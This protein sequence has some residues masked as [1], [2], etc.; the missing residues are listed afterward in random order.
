MSTSFCPLQLAMYVWPVLSCLSQQAVADTHVVQCD[1][2][3][4]VCECNASASVCHFQFNVELVYTFMRHNLSLPFREGEIFFFNDDGELV[5]SQKK[6]MCIEDDLVKYT[7][8]GYNGVPFE[9]YCVNVTTIS[10]NVCIDKGKLCT[11]PITVDSMTFKPVIAINKQFPGPTLILHEGQTIVVDVHNNLISESVSIHWHGQHQV[12]TNWMDGVGLVTQSPIQPE[13]S[14]RYIFKASPSGTFWY[15]S[16]M[17]SQRANGLFGALVVRERELSYPISFEDNPSAHTITLMDW[18]REDLTQLISRKLQTYIDILTFAVPTPADEKYEDT[19]SS[20]GTKIGNIPYWCGLINGK[21]KHPSVAY[22]QSRLTILEVIQ[23]H[24]YRF[25]LIHT[26]VHYAYRFSIDGHKVTVM[27]TDGYI[28]QPTEVDYIAI[29]SGERYDFLLKARKEVDNFWIIAE[30]FEADFGRSCPYSSLN[31]TAEGILHY[32]GSTSPTSKEYGKILRRPRKCT[33]GNR[34]KMLNCPF[35]EFHSS[36]NIECI[37]VDTLKLVSPTQASQMPDESPDLT[38][39]LNIAGFVSRNTTFSSINDKNFVFPPNPPAL[40][41]DSIPS[42][43]FCD[44]NINCT[45]DKI[46]RCTTVIDFPYNKTIRVVMSS[47]GIERNAVHPM[48]LHGHS[49]HVVA[50]GHGTYSQDDGILLASSRDLSCSGDMDDSSTMDQNRC[51]NPRWRNSSTHFSLDQFTVRKDTIIVPSGGYVV[52]QF[53]SDNPGF[54][55]LHCHMDVHLHEGLAL[56][57]REAIDEMTR[58]PEGMSMCGSFTWDVKSFDAI[59]TGGQR[60]NTSYLLLFY[61]YILILLCLC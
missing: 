28:V 20:D 60:S 26:G 48:H 45:I 53:R 14:F 56:I 4:A 15:H 40:D 43:V 5:T 42:N 47:I 35:R 59:V 17:G 29:H 8:F 3:D 55:F 16:H 2:T 46:C 54:W 51:P 9:M 33:E 11:A 57:M 36:Y 34:C 1:S 23:G 52:I 37:S 61:M 21:G 30:T 41:Y 19:F 6:G 27:A 22:T 58:A 10:S 13:N 49:F 7:T 50:I 25:R 39:F 24:T 31:H 18:Y 44:A 12:R 32:L 38:Y